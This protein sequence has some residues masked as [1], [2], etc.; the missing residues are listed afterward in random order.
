MEL[1]GLRDGTGDYYISR[2]ADLNLGFETLQVV[3]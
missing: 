1:V 3:L 2:D